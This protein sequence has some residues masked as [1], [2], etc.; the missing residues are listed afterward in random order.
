MARGLGLISVLA[1]FRRWGSPVVVGSRVISRL[2]ALHVAAVV[3]A[4]RRRV[5]R[6]VRLVALVLSWGLRMMVL[7]VC[8]V[9]RVE[10]RWVLRTVALRIL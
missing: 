4:E 10:I 5:R 1:L 2:Y 6:R 8:V 3:V 9:G 7:R